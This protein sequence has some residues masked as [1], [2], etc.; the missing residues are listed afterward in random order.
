MDKNIVE[1]G[2]VRTDERGTF[3]EILNGGHWENLIVGRMNT[4]AVLGHH[5]HQKTT[6]FF[7]LQSGSATIGI[8]QVQTGQRK[9]VSL[10]ANHGIV[11]ETNESHAIRFLE[12][13]EFFMLKSLRYDP[14][15]PDTIPYPVPDP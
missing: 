8:V 4:G 3:V 2:F 7:F 11:L 6:I 10:K 15:D 14:A 9:Q 5:Y 1:P 12:N 13:S